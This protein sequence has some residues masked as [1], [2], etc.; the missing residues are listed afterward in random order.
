MKTNILGCYYVINC[1]WG[2]YV[3]NSG[4]QG[5]LICERIP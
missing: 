4:N 2:G 3:A 1:L 5:V